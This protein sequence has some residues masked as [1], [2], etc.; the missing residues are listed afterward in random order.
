[1]LTDSQKSSIAINE[2]LTYEQKIAALRKG[3]ASDEEIKKLKITPSA[4]D[5]GQKISG[6]ASKISG[7]LSIISGVSMIITSIK[8]I[9]TAYNDALEE[10]VDAKKTEVN[11]IQ[12]EIYTQAHQ[13]TTLDNLVV[14][15]DKLNNQIVKSTDYMSEMDDVRQGLIDALG[16]DASVA[17]DISTQQ[18]RMDAESKS[19]Q[20][21]K[22]I[23]KNVDKLSDTL[24]KASGSVDAFG[25]ITSEAAI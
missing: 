15:Y 4:A 6:V 9:T 1:M 18:L 23:E 19:A 3:G 7:I 16:Y 24:T 11:S 13:R 17:K 25:N 21:D 5:K 22:D 20:L 10:A 2:G 14:S 12:S 8:N